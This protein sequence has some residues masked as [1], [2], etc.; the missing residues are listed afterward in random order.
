[1]SQQHPQIIQPAIQAVVVAAELGPVHLHSFPVAPEEPQVAAAHVVVAV[2]GL[3][4]EVEVVAVIM[5]EEEVAM[6]QEEV[7]HLTYL[8]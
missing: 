3:Q 5:V 2:Q 6:R 4:E 1:M 7:A 8:A